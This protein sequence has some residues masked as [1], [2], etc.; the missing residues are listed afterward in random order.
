MARR[1]VILIATAVLCGA[2]SFFTFTRTSFDFA[3]SAFLS[4]DDAEATNL[5]RYLSEWGDDTRWVFV[6]LTDPDGRM[7]SL[8]NLQYVQGLQETLEAMAG[9]ESV[10]TFLTVTSIS[11]DD[12]VITI[13]PITSSLPSTEA[14]AAE[15][16]RKALAD[17]FIMGVLLSD[18]LRISVTAVELSK[19]ITAA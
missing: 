13:G 4:A 3:Y 10:K 12:D 8:R 9:I 14:E 15:V 5:S 19:E 7:T 18:D 17:P 1:R 2:A 11:G 6:G 16:E